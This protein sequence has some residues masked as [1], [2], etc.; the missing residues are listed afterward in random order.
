MQPLS[1]NTSSKSDQIPIIVQSTSSQPTF[2]L[3][4]LLDVSAFTQDES[5]DHSN[6]T[7]ASVGELTQPYLDKTYLS[8][9]REALA[10][11]S[12]NEDT[13]CHSLGALEVD[14]D[15]EGNIYCNLRR[16]TFPL[17][18]KDQFEIE[19]NSESIYSEI[20]KRTNPL[21]NPQLPLSCSPSTQPQL[22]LPP[23][24]ISESVCY[25]SVKP[26]HRHQP[27]VNNSQLGYL[28]QAQ[29]LDDMNEMEEAISSTAHVTPTEPFGT[30]KH[31]LAEIISKDLAKFQAP[32]PSGVVNPTF[33]Q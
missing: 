30:F 10:D 27:P 1:V 2:P 31:R 26:R 22:Q 18:I 29:G 12:E 16:D 24:S 4:E 33:S 14:N 13:L 25:T 8:N 21:S 11:E 6:I 9:S 19:G 7:E 32:P 3:Y 17:I 15:M 5:D 28:A 23:F 20:K